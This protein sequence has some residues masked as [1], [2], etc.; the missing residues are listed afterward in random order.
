MKKYELLFILPGTLDEKEAQTQ[1]EAVL[2][3]VKEQDAAAE[4]KLLGK[5][6]LAYPIRQIRYG[7]FYLAF[8]S[9]ETAGLKTLQEKLALDRDL[10]RRMITDYNEK[11]NM[12]VQPAGKHLTDIDEIMANAEEK[13]EKVYEPK[14]KATPTMTIQE[15]DKKL[16]EILDGNVIPSV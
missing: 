13:A 4:L 8:F 10:L 16:D 9:V 7:Y 5:N 2:Q 3:L 12:A 14:K 15:I 11:F 6:R 1:A